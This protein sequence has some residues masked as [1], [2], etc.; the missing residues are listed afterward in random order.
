VRSLA[1]PLA[2]VVARVRRRPERWLPA[3]DQAARAALWATPALQRAV[4][5]TW[6]GPVSPSVD[7]HA[8]AL[9]DGLGLRSQPRVALLNP[10]RLSGLV[11]RP[12][13]ITPL[14]RWVGVGE[15]RRWG[16]APSARVRCCWSGGRFAAGG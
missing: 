13:A 2:L 16:A 8:R 1:A 11:V 9:L 5:V 15:P 10:V 6:Q 3:G 14:Q 4:Q 12:V 7:R